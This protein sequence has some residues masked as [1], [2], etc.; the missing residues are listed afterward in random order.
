MSL[1][2]GLMLFISLFLLFACSRDSTKGSSEGK[3]SE[4]QNKLSELKKELSR[5]NKELL[6]TKDRASCRSLLSQVHELEHE[7]FVIDKI[8]K[9]KGLVDPV[10][11]DPC[12]DNG[13]SPE[14]VKQNELSELK[15]ELSKKN[16]ELL[17]T[18]DWASCRKLLSQV[19]GLREE[20]FKIEKGDVEFRL[21]YP[22]SEEGIGSIAYS[23]GSVSYIDPC[24]DNGYSSME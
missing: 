20:I 13:Y 9:G 8:F 18:K 23:F 16:E 14:K 21:H 19:V 7:I 2:S 10:S 11:L 17:K 4:E 15:A 12:T 1:K 6:K 22:R 5:K 24:T 3:P